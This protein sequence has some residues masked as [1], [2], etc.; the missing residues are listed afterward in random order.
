MDRKKIHELVKDMDEK[1]ELAFL[2]EIT[3]KRIERLEKRIK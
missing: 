3:K 2:E 1:T